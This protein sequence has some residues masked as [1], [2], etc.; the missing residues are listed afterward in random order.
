MV[1]TPLRIHQSLTPIGNV[2]QRAN[3]LVSAMAKALNVGS[4]AEPA[5]IRAFKEAEEADREYRVAVRKLDRQRLGL[6]ERLE[7]SLKTLQRWETERLRA[8][9]T[10]KTDIAFRFRLSDQ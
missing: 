4:Q 2:P 3:T 9:K 10:G 7:D 6:E 1:A 8:I 5:H